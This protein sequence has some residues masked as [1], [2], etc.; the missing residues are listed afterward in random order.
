MFNQQ[1][2]RLTQSKLPALIACLSIL[3]AL[4]CSESFA[5]DSS[6]RQAMLS[7]VVSQKNVVVIR[8]SVKR[9]CKLDSSLTDALKQT[10]HGELYDMPLYTSTRRP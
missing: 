4:I 5:Q 10:F 6:S 3:L 9:P 2:M 7:I 1:T 8:F